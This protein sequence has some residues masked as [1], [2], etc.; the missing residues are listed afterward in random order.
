[1]L[2]GEMEE[3]DDSCFFNSSGRLGAAGDASCLIACLYIG[4]GFQV[5]LQREVLLIR[6]PP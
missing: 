2:K 4:K 5:V 6:G 3:E 1:M